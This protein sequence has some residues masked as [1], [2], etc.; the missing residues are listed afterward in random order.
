[1]RH[2]TLSTTLLAGTFSLLLAGCSSSSAPTADSASTAPAQPLAAAASLEDDEIIC[3]SRKATGS[4]FKKTRCV[5][6]TVYEREAEYAQDELRK[7]NRSKL[8]H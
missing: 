5:T 1:M 6:K 4:N 3:T 7:F 2:T 8:N